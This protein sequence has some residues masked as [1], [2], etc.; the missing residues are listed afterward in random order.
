MLKKI[1]NFIY[2]H[3]LTG[4]VFPGIILGIAFISLF[5]FFFN[6]ADTTPATADDYKPLIAIKDEI[7]KDFNQLYKYDNYSVEPKNDNVKVTLKNDECKLICLFSKDMKLTDYEKTS[8]HFSLAFGVFISAVA[9]ACGSFVSL[10]FVC[11][12]L[13]LIY[14]LLILLEVICKKLVE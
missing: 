1:Y 12:A 2:D 3:L 9:A 7:S 4:K 11:L 5:I 8:T 10:F 6:T 13:G 14:L